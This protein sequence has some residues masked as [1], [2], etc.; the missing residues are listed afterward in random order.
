MTIERKLEKEL[1]DYEKDLSE[2]EDTAKIRERVS[3]TKRLLES[4]RKSLYDFF[5]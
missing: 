3:L 1:D 5:E 4:V 2:R